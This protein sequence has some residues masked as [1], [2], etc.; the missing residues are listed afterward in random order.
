MAFIN[1]QAALVTL[2]VDSNEIY[3]AP[4]EVQIRALTVHNPTA[5][6][7]DLVVTVAGVQM[8]TKTIVANATEV[9]SQLFNQQLKKTEVL[10]ISGTG[11]N[12]MLT[13]VEITE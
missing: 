5:E 1:K 10:S 4:T 7:I 11:A 12:V 6:N 3:T 8:L 13:V 2:A 9:L